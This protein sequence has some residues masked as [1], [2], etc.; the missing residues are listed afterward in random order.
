VRGT[1]KLGEP[2]LRDKIELV[3]AGCGYGVVVRIPPEA[4]PMCRATVWEHA[5]WRP[6]A[7]GHSRDLDSA[8][9]R[10]AGGTLSDDERL[11]LDVGEELELPAP[12]AQV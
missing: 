11:A 7:Q 3:C 6:F 5:P 4:C 2:P 9:L 8:L 1:F 12:A 10:A